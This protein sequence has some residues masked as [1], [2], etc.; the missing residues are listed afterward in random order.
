[1][2]LNVIKTKL[3]IQ[4]DMHCYVKISIRDYILNSVR[5]SVWDAT[6]DTLTQI[7]RPGFFV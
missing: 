7:I 3:I 6:Y 5:D 4:N 2:N 1:M